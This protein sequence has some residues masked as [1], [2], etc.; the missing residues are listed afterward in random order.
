MRREIANVFK[1]LEFYVG[2]A[3]HFNVLH[4]VANILVILN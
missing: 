3:S 4:A 2:F 1:M